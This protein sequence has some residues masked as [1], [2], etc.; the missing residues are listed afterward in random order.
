MVFK[1]ANRTLLWG[2][3]GIK[4]NPWLGGWRSLAGGQGRGMREHM[5]RKAGADKNITESGK[6]KE[7]CACA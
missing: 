1:R 5:Y 7:Q 2:N 4:G 6:E 3:T